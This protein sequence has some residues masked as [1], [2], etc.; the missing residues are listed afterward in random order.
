M[1]KPKITITDWDTMQHYKGKGRRKTSLVVWVKLYRALRQDRRWRLLSPEGC[2]LYIDL[3]LLS[4]D[5]APYG[6]IMLPPEALAWE[7]RLT[8]PDLLKLLAEA[9]ASGLIGA[10]GYHAD[11]KMLAS[12]YVADSELSDGSLPDATLEVEEEVDVEVE[13]T[14]DQPTKRDSSKLYVDAEEFR[15]FGKDFGVDPAKIE[16]ILGQ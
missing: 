6:S 3:L 7:L 10:T 16:A 14:N 5:E 13:T 2:K 1:T 11:L 8:V 9:D 12:G 4:A 15:L